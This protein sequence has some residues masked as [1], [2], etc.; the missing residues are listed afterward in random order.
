[1]NPRGGGTGTPKARDSRGVT[2]LNSTV[3]FVATAAATA[4]AV[5]WLVTF[6]PWARYLP[7]AYFVPL[8]ILVFPL[9]GWSAYVL[10]AGQ[11]PREPG[12]PPAEP[13]L[14]LERVKIP[15]A[16]AGSVAIV[17]FGTAIP[18]LASG[19]P[20]YDRRHHRYFY[21]LHGTLVPA[22]RTGYLHAIAAQNRLFLGFALIFLTGAAVVTREARSRRRAEP[23]GNRPQPPGQDVLGAA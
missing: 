5:S 12:Q 15:I 9:A 14:E 7:T 2:V 21:N 23:G 10:K 20:G 6:T 11:R 16:L 8:F 22:T 3:C 17:S 1:M 13:L 19:T 18:S 4:A